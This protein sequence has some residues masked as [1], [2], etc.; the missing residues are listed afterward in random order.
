MPCLQVSLLVRHNVAAA[1]RVAATAQLLAGGEGAEQ[2][3]VARHLA[4]IQAI[5]AQGAD[6]TL[7]LAIG[8]ALTGLDA[9][10]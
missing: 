6:D 2:S 5:A 1:R 10:N 7:G 3:S 9:L 8:R 4:N